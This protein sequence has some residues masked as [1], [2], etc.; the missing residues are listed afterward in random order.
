MKPKLGMGELDG[1]YFISQPLLSRVGSVENTANLIREVVGAVS[2]TVPRPPHCFPLPE[3]GGPRV[4][5]NPIR[6]AGGRT[7]GLDCSVRVPCPLNRNP[8][9]QW[10]GKSTVGTPSIGRCPDP[11]SPRIKQHLTE[12][13]SPRTTRPCCR[14]ELGN[15]PPYRG[16]TRLPTRH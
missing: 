5:L 8:Q 11:L 3:T 4:S 10:E 14:R 1:Q 6:I 15:L 9:L 7:V 16:R 12:R 2:A 13:V